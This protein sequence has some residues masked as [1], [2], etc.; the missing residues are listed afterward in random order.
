MVIDQ[1]QTL[2]Q[3]EELQPS[4]LP[5]TP[6]RLLYCFASRLLAGSGFLFPIPDPVTIGLYHHGSGVRFLNFSMGCALKKRSSASR[7]M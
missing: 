7:F 3:L 2:F 6:S 1:S 5:S 4:V